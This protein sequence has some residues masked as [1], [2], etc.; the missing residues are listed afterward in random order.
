VYET[1]G[2]PIHASYAL[3]QLRH[4]YQDH[5]DVSR[6]VARW[7][8]LASCC[9][10]R[11]M[12]VP[13]LPISYSEA[14]WTGL[15]DYR[16]CRYA[17]SVQQLV[18]AECWTALPELRDYDGDHPQRMIRQGLPEHSR[19]YD[20]WPELR[21]STTRFFL[22]V[23]DGACATIGSKCT[24][25]NRIACTIGTSAAARICV[26]LSVTPTHDDDDDD[27]QTQHHGSDDKDDVFVPGLF[28]Y[29]VNRTSVVV[30]GALTDGGSVVEWARTML[31]LDASQDAYD[32]CL[33][34]VELMV[35]SD[36]AR[37]AAEESD[38]RPADNAHTSPAGSITF[39]PFLSGERNPGFRETASG[40][41]FGLRRATRPAHVLK[42]C[43]EGVTLRINAIVSLLR[44]TS[45]QTLPAPTSGDGIHL[46]ASGGA[47]ESNWLWRQ[48]LA[49]CTGI[50]V[51][52]DEDAN[53]STS[54]GVAL[55]VARALVAADVYM[56]DSANCLQSSRIVEALK[57]KLVSN[58]RPV[59]SRYWE[60]L[61]VEQNRL[62]EALDPLYDESETA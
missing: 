11:W 31:N 26:P 6:R 32:A 4:L 53:E 40:C 33:L 52:F 59:L 44:S 8:T 55:L 20:R 46:V 10:S 25:P 5:P 16:T 58:P 18:P 19:Y 38:G 2:A 7:Q 50:P 15:L 22:G 14:S 37:A 42:S 21:Q 41:M 1:T 12:G 35:S 13:H 47:L 61:A 34:E 23:G 3:A 9:L 30:G 27:N 51:V 57:P 54:R 39:V 17:A 49:D 48:M 29:R 36:L 62:L 28:C 56:D 24:I 60:R 43:L 45:L